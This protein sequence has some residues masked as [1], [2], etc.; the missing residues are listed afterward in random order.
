MLMAKILRLHI[1]PSDGK[2][3]RAQNLDVSFPLTPEVK[4]LIADMKTTVKKAAGI[5]L[6][7]PQVGVNIKLAVIYLEEF[8]LKGFTIINPVVVSRSI[9]KS[10]M[11]EGCL[12]IPGVFGPVKR[13][14]KV[15]VFAQTEEGTKILI[16]GDGLL[17]KVLQHEIDHL[18][19]V[20]IADKIIKK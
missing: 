6:A 7:A 17:G 8:G 3:L 19:G 9:K 10:I 4:K 16:Q 15:E 20:L 12:S 1:L 5:G 13:P 2:V 18:N 14:A 11:Q